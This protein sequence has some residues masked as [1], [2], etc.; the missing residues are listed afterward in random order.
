MAT[1]NDFNR[2]LIE[3]FRAKNGKVEGSFEGAPLLLL[4]TTGAKSG[5]PRTTPLV[6]QRDGDRVVIFGSKGG[7]PAHPAW[8]HNLVA[9]PE[10]IVE[11]P[12]EKFTAHAEVAEGAERQ[13]LWERQK[14]AMPNF[15]EYEAKTTR[16]IPAIVLERVS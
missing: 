13:R 10:V 15:A 1:I 6:Y 2:S 8:F 14:A 11:L 3:E 4:T 7:A 5:Q 12:G 16:E 9:N